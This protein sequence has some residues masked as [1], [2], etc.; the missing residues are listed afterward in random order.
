MDGLG[1]KIL[2]NTELSRPYALTI[3]YGSQTLYWADYDQ[4]KIESSSV[5][6]SNR[7]LLTT[8]NINYP[9]YMTFYAGILYW[10]DI[11]LDDILSLPVSSPNNVTT[12]ASYNSYDPNGV[13]VITEVRQPRG[14][15]QDF[16]GLYL[17]SI[18]LLPVLP[19]QLESSRLIHTC[20]L[21]A[22]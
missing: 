14:Q 15:L 12:V 1:R 11:T 4:D 21:P 6:G 7:I 17:V 13:Q 3:D 19:W 18:Y 16:K 8:M 20:L 5:D 10:S 9:Y 22:S 2:H